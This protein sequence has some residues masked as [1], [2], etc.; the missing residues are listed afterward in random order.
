MGLG[1]TRALESR[2]FV[3]VCTGRYKGQWRG[4]QRY[5]QG[6]LTRPFFRVQGLGF[7]V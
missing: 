1:F 5:G 7:R 2:A 4:Q 3:G 6:V